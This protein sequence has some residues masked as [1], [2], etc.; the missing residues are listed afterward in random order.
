MFERCQLHTLS[1]G[2]ATTWLIADW[3]RPGYVARTAVVGGRQDL[4]HPETF[5]DRMSGLLHGRKSVLLDRG[6]FLRH[7]LCGNPACWD[8]HFTFAR[9]CVA[10]G[11]DSKV[12]AYVSETSARY[13]RVG[14]YKD[15]VPG[16]D[17]W[18][19]PLYSHELCC[20]LTQGFEGRKHCWDGWRLT[21]ERCCVHG[22]DLD[23]RWQLPMAPKQS[24]A[25]EEAPAPVGRECWTN[26][27]SFRACCRL[28]DEEEDLTEDR[29]SCW[30]GLHTEERCCRGLVAPPDAWR[31]VP[32]HA[33]ESLCLEAVLAR[34][35]KLATVS[36]C[37]GRFF[38]VAQ[39]GKPRLRMDYDTTALPWFLVPRWN[40]SA[41]AEYITHFGPQ[42][43]L[44][45]K[46]LG[47]LCLP[48]HCDVASTAQ[49][50]APRVAPWW[51]FPLLEPWPLNGSHVLLP[52]PLA[53]PHGLYPNGDNGIAMWVSKS[54][55]QTP[56]ANPDFCE[57]YWEFGLLEWRPWHSHPLR[58]AAL[59]GAVLMLLGLVVA[60][61][62]P[63][64]E[65]NSRADLLRVLLTLMAVWT[66]TF[67]HGS[68][69]PVEK[70]VAST[71]WFTSQ[72]LT[73]KVNLGFV[74]LAT[75]LRL[76]GSSSPKRFPVA[77][78]AVRR[79]LQ[80]GPP[81]C[82]S[83]FI[84]LYIFVEHIPM[85]NLMKS[86]GLHRWYSEK[87][88]LE[89]QG[90]AVHDRFLAA[91]AA[92]HAKYSEHAAEHSCCPDDKSCPSAAVFVVPVATS[93]GAKVIAV[94]AEPGKQREQMMIGAIGGIGGQ[95]LSASKVDCSP[96]GQSGFGY[97]GKR[98]PEMPEAFKAD[99]SPNGPSGCGFQANWE[100]DFVQKAL[101]SRACWELQSYIPDCSMAELKFMA[102][103][104]RGHVREVT[105]SPYGNH[106]LQ[107]MIE[108]MAPK[109][110]DF[111]LE[112]M[113]GW[114]P[115]LARD[116]YGCREAE[117]EMLVKTVLKV[118]GL[119]P[120]MKSLRGGATA[121]ESVL[122]TAT[123]WALSEA[124]RLECRRPAHLVLSLLL[125]HEPI[126]GNNSPCHNMDIFESQF[127][128]DLFVV[129]LLSA[130]GTSRRTST[131][132]LLWYASILWRYAGVRSEENDW[133]YAY[134]HR[135]RMLLP[136]AIGA[137]G[138][139]GL[140]PCLRGAG[141]SWWYDLVGLVLVSGSC[142]QDQ[143]LFG[144]NLQVLFK[145]LQRAVIFNVSELL[146]V[147]GFLLLLRPP[148]CG[149][150]LWPGSC[151]R[152]LSR[153]SLGVNVSNL[154]VFHFIGGS[155]LDEP[156]PMSVTMVLLYF[157]LVYVVSCLLA[158][159]LLALQLPL[160]LAFPDFQSTF[161][162]H[163]IIYLY[164][165]V[166]RAAQLWQV[167]SAEDRRSWCCQC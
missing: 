8:G 136:S 73:Y 104:L 158:L 148:G 165:F 166:E 137:I 64:A 71:F 140:L 33:P 26:G 48:S 100:Q 126:T 127:L 51:R 146:F 124:Q 39:L 130:F 108:Y 131:S 151:I 111:L 135:F 155:L 153:L 95:I 79:W 101:D 123:G 81:L 41:W 138:L 99:E 132:W 37:E 85:N 117:R 122:H 91:A 2:R 36:S 163:P 1:D 42:G 38:Y 154:F 102:N 44:D 133:A 66:H 143:L 103:Q 106:V 87:R 11:E 76:A 134:S 70:S 9:C 139:W 118:E 74:V 23:G 94:P 84:Y 27:Y 40:T 162:D 5:G 50:L 68:W 55:C 119:L 56:L 89:P 113:V 13:Q 121:I 12:A 61:K 120:F 24:E 47:G 145:P 152:L 128:L 112:E 6:L 93:A 49:F 125:L 18:D 167:W 28:G 30:D 65:R 96:N 45:H 161:D 110:L 88:G 59:L 69:L 60:G 78:A 109:S 164:F 160:A 150:R 16:K 46:V 7:L 149:N 22:E 4:G 90:H 17:C 72:H 75:Q 114:A 14:L 10:P 159:M 32:R 58:M 82:L 19:P 105:Q 35:L 83:T 67:S 52:P 62:R 156:L 129:F 80:L 63:T 98:E 34:P 115:V 97:Y 43:V 3:L 15:Y 147:L 141:T 20:D 29:A 21:F 157:A 92:E 107:L 25:E 86:S 142:L 144:D 53:L 31:A 116:R 57:A 77:K 54:S